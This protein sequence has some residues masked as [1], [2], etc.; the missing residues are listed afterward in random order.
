MPN[1][2]RYGNCSDILQDR[3]LHRRRGRLR[4]RHPRPPS[5]DGGHDKRDAAVGVAAVV[6]RDATAD[7]DDRGM[8][9]RRVPT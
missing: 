3:R 4:H 6:R 5:I 8:T 2:R 1:C 7:G 9:L